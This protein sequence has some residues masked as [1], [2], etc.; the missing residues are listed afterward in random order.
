MQ[1]GFEP[2]DPT[3]Y[4]VMKFILVQSAQFVIYLLLPH[5]V[6]TE[7]SIPLQGCGDAYLT[8][9]E[10]QYAH[11]NNLLVTAIAFPKQEL[12]RRQYCFF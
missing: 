10:F 3:I 9:L 8:L 12:I 7:K 4:P 5:L 1:T 6:E 11:I 2:L